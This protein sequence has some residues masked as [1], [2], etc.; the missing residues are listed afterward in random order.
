MM[1][2]S[3]KQG[4]SIVIFPDVL[5]IKDIQNRKEAPEMLDLIS[6]II[7]FCV[8]GLTS[9]YVILAVWLKPSF[10]PHN[11]CVFLTPTVVVCT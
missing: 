11:S 10:N 1:I 4:R 9:N 8:Y 6:P 2:V 3:E 5:G 7:S